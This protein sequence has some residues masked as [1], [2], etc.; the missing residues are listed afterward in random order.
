LDGRLPSG[1]EE[2][3]AAQARPCISIAIARSIDDELAQKD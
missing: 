3:E 1:A 2:S